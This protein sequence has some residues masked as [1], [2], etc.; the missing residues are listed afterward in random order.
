MKRFVWNFT[1]SVSIFNY[2]SLLN[3]YEKIFS[4]FTTKTVFVILRSK[5]NL[6]RVLR[7]VVNIHEILNANQIFSFVINEPCI[8]QYRVPKNS[9]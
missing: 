1:A 4:K 5:I 6:V 3:F 7:R 9:Q 2:F 8:T